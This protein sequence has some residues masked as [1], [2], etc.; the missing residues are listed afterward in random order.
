MVETAADW[1]G[2]KYTLNFCGKRITAKATLRLMLAMAFI[3]VVAVVAL[4]V[5]VVW[6]PPGAASTVGGHRARQ[7]H[8]EPQAPPA[9]VHGAL[10][11]TDA[12]TSTSEQSQ[13]TQ[14]VDDVQLQLPQNVS[15]TPPLVATSST[16][17]IGPGT[18]YGTITVGKWLS[19]ESA[20]AW[21]GSTWGHAV[22]Y[23]ATQPG[24]AMEL[25][26]YAVYCP[27]GGGNP[28]LGGAAKDGDM[29]SPTSDRAN[30][31]VQVGVWSGDPTTTCLGHHEI[32]GGVHGDPAWGTDENRHSFMRWVLCCPPGTAA[33]E[34]TT[35]ASIW[36][37]AWIEGAEN[38]NSW[39]SA[40]D[41]CVS[42][43]AADMCPYEVYCPNGAGSAPF[44]GR[45]EGDMWSPYSGD[46]ESVL[47][48]PLLS[49]PSRCRCCL[50]HR[51]AVAS[52]SIEEGL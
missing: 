1:L 49:P 27:D 17:A 51:G 14:N 19:D 38:Y 44:G 23:C 48:L 47:A 29:W 37:G 32:A 36:G 31:W 46:G 41:Y 8:V 7:Q 10:G 42:I 52:G 33:L 16:A 2:Q 21:D 30:M 5:V 13:S 45:R 11:V 24:G 28:P 9:A 35:P 43:G 12:S 26:P 18:N 3:T 39:G 4:I 50:H 20:P 15:P 22:D 34:T 25:C 6:T 40:S